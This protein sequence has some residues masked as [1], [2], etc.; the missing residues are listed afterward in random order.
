MQF[1][2]EK[3]RSSH[4]QCPPYHLAVVIGC[5]SAEFA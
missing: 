2:E 1:L 4:G 5:T 3:L